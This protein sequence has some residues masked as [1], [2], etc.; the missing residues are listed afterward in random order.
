MSGNTV[1]TGFEFKWDVVDLTDNA[2]TVSTRRSILRGA[3]INTTV[4]LAT[5]IKNGTD[6]VFTLP[7]STSPGQFIAFGDVVFDAGIVIDP[8]DSATGSITVVYKPV[9]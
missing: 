5:I 6:T 9:L 8:D 7:A 3:Y 4:S 2:T 1:E